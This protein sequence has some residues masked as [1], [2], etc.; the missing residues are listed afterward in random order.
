V[1]VPTAPTSPG[2]FSADGSG[3]GPGYI[4]NQDGTLNGP[5]HPAKIGDQITIFATGV[6]PVTSTGGSAV[7]GFAPNVIIDGYNCDGTIQQVTG[8]TCSPVAATFGPV[9]GFPGS[10]YKLTM[11]IPYPAGYHVPPSS[12]ALSVNGVVSQNGLSIYI[13]NN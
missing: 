9:T 7:T 3:S 10:V 8:V 1:P 6:G 12:I 13:S 2:L 5:A 11:I 4:L